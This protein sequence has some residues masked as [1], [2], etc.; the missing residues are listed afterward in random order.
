MAKQSRSLLGIDITPYEIRVA[1]FRTA[2]RQDQIVQVG[3]TRTPAGSMHGDRISDPGA[4]A[5]TLRGLLSRM[6]VSTKAAVVGIGPQ[7]VITHVLDIPHVPD[8]EIRTVVEGELAHLHV[9]PTGTGAFDYLKIDA[10]PSKEDGAPQALVMAAESKTVSAA[11]E[12]ASLA[13]L[14]LIAIEPALAAMYRFAYAQLHDLASV[15][16]LSVGYSKSEIAIL[17]HG[18][19]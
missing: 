5:S 18:D 14:Q 17:D 12:V 16:F 10:P 13:G 2:G 8:D 7:Q 1:E 15:A 3:S 9:L 19:I 6:A 11:V 4:V